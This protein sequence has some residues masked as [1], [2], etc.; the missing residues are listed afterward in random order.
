[1]SPR[2]QVARAALSCCVGLAL[3]A[4][5]V[6]S[7]AG[8]AYPAGTPVAQAN[9]VEKKAA[10]ARYNEGAGLFARARYDEALESFKASYAVVA[11]PNSQLMIARCLIEL[12]K[13]L[14]AYVELE[15][16]E[17]AAT[18]A[19]AGDPRYAETADKAKTLRG[20]LRAKLAVVRLSVVGGADVASAG[21]ITIDGVEVPAASWQEPRVVAPGQH[22]ITGSYYGEVRFRASETL[23][24]GDDKEIVIDLRAA[25]AAPPPLPPAGPTPVPRQE[26][27]DI[28]L[29]PFA[30][31]A[32]GVGVAGLILF[33]ITGTMNATTYSDLEALCP[34][35][36]CPDSE[37]VSIEARK[38]EGRTQQTLANVGLVIGL[39]GLTIGGALLTI[40]LMSDDDEGGA[41]ASEPRAWV[42][43]GP[44]S[45]DLTYSF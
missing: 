22:Q 41:A 27:D 15:R 35:G 10:Q 40:E 4:A 5:S 13:P 3:L 2:T 36:R 28:S 18:Q 12:D 31:T 7:A 9:P 38:S 33:A 19:A 32:G 26:S 37:G 14:E 25:D 34:E 21:M 20:E 39:A 6:P 1:M 30:A 11:S 44:S 8:E 45:V 42:G 29:I 43:V 17:A 23:A 24:A 16:V